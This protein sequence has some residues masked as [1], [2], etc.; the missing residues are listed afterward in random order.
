MMLFCLS[1]IPE[2][3]DTVFLVLR[4]KPVIFL[5]WYHHIVTLLYCWW[6]WSSQTG[7]GGVFAYM[8]LFVHSIMYSYYGVMAT[9]FRCEI[10]SS[11]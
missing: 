4:K 2:L 11:K 7:S 8:N 10:V 5:H 1:K 9:G 6:G 3:L